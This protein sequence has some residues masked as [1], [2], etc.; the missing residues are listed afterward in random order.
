MYQ[1]ALEGIQLLAGLAA[2][3]WL[4]RRSGALSDR[5]AITIGC[6]LIAILAAP[7]GILGDH[8]FLAKGAEGE[9]SVPGLLMMVSTPSS[10][11]FVP[12]L[13][14][15]VDRD[16]FATFSGQMVSLERELI[17][18]L[19]LPM[20]NFV[21]KIGI[22]GVGL[23]GMY[24]LARFFGARPAAAL[25]LGLFFA[26][27][28]PRLTLMTWSHGLGFAFVP[29]FCWLALE[30][31]GKAWLP[32]LAATLVFAASCTPTHSLLA[33]LMG[34]ACGAILGGRMAWPAVIGGLILTATVANWHEGLYAKAL[35]GP[36][37]T[38]GTEATNTFVVPSLSILLAGTG[39]ALAIWTRQKWVWRYGL[40]LIAAGF[41]GAAAQWVTGHVDILRPVAALNYHNM[42]VA[43]PA[44]A[45]IGIASLL[46]GSPAGSGPIRLALPVSG[47]IAAAQVAA[48]LAVVGTTW[49]A[50]GGLGTITGPLADLRHRPWQPQEPTRVVSMPWRLPANVA[51]AAG[52]DTFDGFFP[53]INRR[54]ETY[55]NGIIA[56]AKVEAASASL[57]IEDTGI[58]P[59]CCA[60]FDLSRLVNLDLLRAANVSHVLS[61]VPLTGP[62]IVQVAGPTGPTPL[63]LRDAPAARR[64]G[65][66]FR[67]ILDPAKV[68]VYALGTPTPRLYAAGRPIVAAHD[69]IIPRIA[70][71]AGRGEVFALAEELP[72]LPPE[73]AA[74]DLLK[75]S[76]TERGARVSISGN[77][78]GLVV[79]N[80]PY[81]GFWHATADGQ[82]VPTFP[83]NMI[84][85]AALVPAGATLVEF[86]YTRPS[87]ADTL[88]RQVRKVFD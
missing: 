77:K 75:A 1:A 49:L 57:S 73:M 86:T 27:S 7:F 11:V 6:V 4:W 54:V 22:M 41:G 51:A 26:F 39:L 31:P 37:T 12:E 68:R 29:L 64:I 9:Y 34:L 18:L 84:Q 72:S 30:R 16:A 66:L 2:L 20:A 59:R 47:G 78:P 74:P 8:S 17:R 38:R 42:D 62:D 19:P 32:A 56:P 10:Q 58:D 15:G 25:A 71:G 52:L 28:H 63:P 80:T 3:L 13:A 88:S 79:F 50:D 87:L 24:R 67:L 5:Q 85:T 14:G 36:L 45:A 60:D 81:V 40:A 23:F 65:T 46:S 83:V 69:Q 21:H 44:I 43:F 61:V 70:D 55:W 82:P 33:V 53:M 35:L 48:F 76:T